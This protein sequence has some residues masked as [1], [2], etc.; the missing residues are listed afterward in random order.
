MKIV[1]VDMMVAPLDFRGQAALARTVSQRTW[2]S[3]AQ[4]RDRG[5]VPEGRRRV[6]LSDWNLPEPAR[7]RPQTTGSRER[8]YREARQWR[9]GR[10]DPSPERRSGRLMLY[11]LAVLQHLHLFERHE[12][13]RHH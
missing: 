11:A 13:A 10:L 4:G 9:R 5:A 12:P 7:N 6:A 2:Q 8:P 3:V 1:G